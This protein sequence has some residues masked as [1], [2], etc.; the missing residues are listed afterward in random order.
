MHCFVT[1]MG[2]ILTHWTNQPLAA[3]SGVDA[4][5]IEDFSFVEIAF[6]AA[7]I[8][9]PKFFDLIWFDTHQ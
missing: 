2:G 7:E 4:D 8:A 6:C 9:H 5:E 3:A 1:F